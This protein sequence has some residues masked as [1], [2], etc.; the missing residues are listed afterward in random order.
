MILALIVALAYGAV[1]VLVWL[2]QR[3]L[4]FFP[5]HDAPPTA[6]EPWVQAGNVIGY[7]RVIEK[8]QTIWLMAHGNAG[9]AAHRAYV[10]PHLPAHDSLYVLEYPGY[11]VRRGQPSRAAFDQAAAAAYEILRHDFPTT[12]VGVIGESIGSGP[13]SA[14]AA[15]AQ[16][17]DKIVL[18][19]PF[20]VF[21]GV[22]SE[23]MP[24]L[25]VRLMLK[26]NW[27]NIAALKTFAGPIDIYGATDDRVIGLAHARNLA[28]Q[29][30]Q[31]RFIEIP[32]GHNDWSASEL[33]RIQR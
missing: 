2:N 3:S 4:I 14:L 20:D 25:P 30:K 6:L 21:A 12:P 26:D 5:S 24:F 18:I 7:C 23:R 19:V 1:V 31:A 13:A 28:A 16:P 8:P 15:A 29:L 10:L 22:A 32:G 27:D 33:V 11:G 9:Q 17:P